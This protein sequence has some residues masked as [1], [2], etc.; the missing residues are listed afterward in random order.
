MRALPLSLTDLKRE[1]NHEEL[2]QSQ[3][4][5]AM[6]PISHSRLTSLAACLQVMSAVVLE[7]DILISHCSTTQQA[8]ASI[9]HC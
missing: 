8:M 1:I 9:G 6:R 5:C 7:A 3:Y 4:E 2:R